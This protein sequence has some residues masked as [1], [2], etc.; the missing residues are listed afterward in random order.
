MST[1]QLT[2][3]GFELIWRRTIEVRR[4][5]MNE[6]HHAPALAHP[7]MIEVGISI[8]QSLEH[9]LIGLDWNDDWI[10]VDCGPRAR[11]QTFE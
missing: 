1:E 7:P 6:G 4:E 5:A 9:T 2:V 8:S 11:R 3:F 10:G